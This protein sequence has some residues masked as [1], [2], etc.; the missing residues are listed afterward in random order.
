MFLNFTAKV[1]KKILTILNFLLFLT[2]GIILLYFAFRDIS[3][4]DLLSDLKNANYFWIF[5]SLLIGTLGFFI[6]AYRWKMLIE[7]L[8]YKPTTKDSFLALMTGYLA[9][10]TLPRFGEVTRC[11]TLNRTNKIPMDALIGTVII[12]RAIDV[13]ILLS[14]AVIIFFAK[15]DFFGQFL[16]TNVL[17]PLHNKIFTTFNFPPVAWLAIILGILVFIIIFAFYRY[18]FSNFPLYKK[19]KKIIL[20]IMDGLKTVFKMKKRIIFI[21]YTVLLWTIYFLMTW[22]VVYSIPATSHLTALDGLFLLVIG[23]LGMAAPV[24]GGIGAFHWIIY[25]GLTIYGITREKGLVYATLS[26]ESQA[27]LV[28]ILGAY[29]FLLLFLQRKKRKRLSFQPESKSAEA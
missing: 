4:R 23:S 28:I 20:G 12:E 18:L 3:F 7:P 6:R 2:L 21:F 27:L 29:S 24:Q 15:I 9:N 16:K 13:I 17:D 8:G 26:H 1:K 14:L 19:I 10:F 25:K 5:L 11:A 22:V